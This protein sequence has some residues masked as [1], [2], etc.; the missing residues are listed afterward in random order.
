M[1][2]H[3]QTKNST[4]FSTTFFPVFQAIRFQLRDRDNFGPEAWRIGC[5]ETPGQTWNVDDPSKIDIAF[6][7]RSDCVLA[8]KSLADAGIF[9]ANELLQL[10]DDTFAELTTRYLSW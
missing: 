3:N 4:L 5:I 10:D 8:I 9:R 2:D 1:L 7:R 6:A